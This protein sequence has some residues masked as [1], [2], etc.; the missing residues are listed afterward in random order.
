MRSRSTQFIVHASSQL[1]RGPPKRGHFSRLIEQ[2]LSAG[3]WWASFS[4]KNAP[5][6]VIM[7]HIYFHRERE[8]E[9]MLFIG[10][11]KGRSRMI[12][13]THQSLSP[14]DTG[15]GPSLS[16]SRM[17]NLNSLKTYLIYNQKSTS[18]SEHAG[19]GYMRTWSHEC[20]LLIDVAFITL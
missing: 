1:G 16:R 19:C 9:I 13:N 10:K 17:V 8:R 2:G 6:P 5:R 15:H 14:E 7:V 4:S 18:E 12:S 20:V 11:P 3:L